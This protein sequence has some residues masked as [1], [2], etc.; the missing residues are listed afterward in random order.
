MGKDRQDNAV[1]FPVL[2]VVTYLPE[3]SLWLPRHVLR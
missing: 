1:M 3:V 2:M